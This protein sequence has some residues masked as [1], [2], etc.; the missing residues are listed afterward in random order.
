M[1]RRRPYVRR[2]TVA[3][4]GLASTV[5]A[6]RYRRFRV[7]DH[8]MT[9][10]IEPGDHLMTDRVWERR[11]LARGDVVVFRSGGRYTVKRVVGLPGE[12][13]GIEGG[14]LM[15]GGRPAVDPWWHAATRPEGEWVVPSDSW[16]V[17]G[18]NR[19][20]SSADSRTLGPIRHPS[21]HSRAVARYWPWRRAGRI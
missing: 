7:V 18:D 10:A 2:G 16:F 19:A 4:L 17:L 21:I 14:V 20:D 1:S 6:S 5:L 13:V 9:P 15:V 3:L 12:T 11:G 8:S